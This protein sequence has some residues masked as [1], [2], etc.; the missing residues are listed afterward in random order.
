MK[1]A[2]T[3]K[4]VAQRVGVSQ[5]AVSYAFSLRADKRALISEQT[6]DRV[7][8]AARAMGYFPNAVAQSIRTGKTGLVALWVPNFT[9]SVY[10]RTM[11][12]MQEVATEHGLDLLVYGDTRE[13]GMAGVLRSIG[14]R[15][16]E[17]AILI[18]RPLEPEAEAVLAQLEIP[19]V[20]VGGSLTYPGVD[21]VLTRNAN[22]FER[23]VGFLAERGYERIGHISGPS[24]APTAQE[25]LDGF[26]RGLKRSKLRFEPR[27]VREGT[28]KAGSAGPLALELARLESKP[29]ALVVANDLMAIEA[30]LALTDHG[31]RVRRTWRLSG[32]TTRR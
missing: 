23:M 26:K 10:L 14:Q 17:G 16:V 25:R 18:A 1:R 2:V 29:Q 8:E 7:L 9:N 4:D 28:Y 24:S 3:A 27:W 31:F 22:A 30:I 20:T 21:R 5:A 13:Q 32:V 15:R 11:R 12:G 6:R 19:L